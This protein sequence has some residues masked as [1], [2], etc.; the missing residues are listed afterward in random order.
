MT[1]TNVT[2]D[3]LNAGLKAPNA[4]EKNWTRAPGTVG[5]SRRIGCGSLRRAPY[6]GNRNPGV[7]RVAASERC[8]PDQ[9]DLRTRLEPASQVGWDVEK[10]GLRLTGQA[11]ARN[12]FV[13]WWD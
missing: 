4:L 1:S 6:Q 3:L 2:Q 5:R 8:D 13:A 7:R 11:T 12:K 10:R 9:V